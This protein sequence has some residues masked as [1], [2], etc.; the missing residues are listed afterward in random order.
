MRKRFHLIPKQSM[1]LYSRNDPLRS[2]FKMASVGARWSKFVQLHVGYPV[3]EHNIILCRYPGTKC[4]NGL[5]KGTICSPL[6]RESKTVLDSGF[7][8]GI[9]DSRYWISDS[10]SKELG[11]RIPIL[12]W[13]SGF[14]ELYSGFQSSGFHKQQFPGFQNPDSL[15]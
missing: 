7:H 13:D 10:L 4:D 8:A 9:L 12:R 14:L 2:R 6:V 15:T 11:S 3:C 1:V 5:R